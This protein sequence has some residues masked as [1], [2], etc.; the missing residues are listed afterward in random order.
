MP[1]VTCGYEV[2]SHN[3]DGQC[4]ASEI[5]LRVPSLATI[6]EITLG[7]SDCDQFTFKKEV[8]DK[9][10]EAMLFQEPLRFSC[11]SLTKTQRNTQFEES[12]K[13]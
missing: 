8:L 2:C 5:T 13:I 9:I 11:Q 7:R 3:E 4:K 12:P 10:K 1:K 6:S